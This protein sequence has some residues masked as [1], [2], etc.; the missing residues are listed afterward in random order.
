MLYKNIHRQF[1]NSVS[2]PPSI[3]PKAIEETPIVAA[4]DIIKGISFGL[5]SIYILAIIIGITH[6][7]TQTK[8]IITRKNSCLLSHICKD[9]PIIS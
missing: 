6:R 9:S 1:K 8:T 5:K 7:N 2:T 3:E 4:I